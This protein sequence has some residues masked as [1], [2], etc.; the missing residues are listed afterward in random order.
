M[1]LSEPQLLFVCH[2]IKWYFDDY[3]LS[4][5]NVDSQYQIITA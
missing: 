5:M 1:T 3:L 2:E 4:L